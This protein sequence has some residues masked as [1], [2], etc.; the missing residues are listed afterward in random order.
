MH[1]AIKASEF[2]PMERELVFD[3][4]LSD[5]DDVST[6]SRLL[7]SAGPLFRNVHISLWRLLGAYFGFWC[8]DL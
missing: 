1:N 5:Y 6:S 8:L 3:I 7:C 2:Q 4:D